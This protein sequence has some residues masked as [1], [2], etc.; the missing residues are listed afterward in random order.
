MIIGIDA[1]GTATKGALIS[2]EEEV[3][4]TFE[5]GYGNPLINEQKAF[6]HIENVMDA[7]KK[8]SKQPIQHI[9]IGM[10]GYRTMKDSLTLPK[11]W[12]NNPNI[13]V[14]SDVELAYEAG[15]PDQEGILTIAGTGTVH[16]GKKNKRLF[17]RGG[18]GHLLGDEGG[19]YT[20]G[21][22]AVKRVLYT[23]E[24]DL[25]QT[26]F[27]EKVMSFI[28]AYDVNE[29]KS[30]F[31]AQDKTSVAALAKFI[32]QLAI[33]G[34]QEAWQLLQE[35]ACELSRQVEQLYCRMELDEEAVL[36]VAGNVL[37]GSE[38][39]FSAFSKKITCPFREVRHLKR[40]AYMGAYSLAGKKKNCSSPSSH[41]I[42]E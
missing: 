35:G 21:R 11:S 34:D 7:C 18:W 15:L 42:F 12:Q 14:I 4:F 17:I 41:S 33:E 38:Q 24:M 13:D 8:A 22:S 40:P 19:G 23:L 1:G 6:E 9:V 31:Y 16:A 5:S 27:C 3:L 26:P 10:A 25:D 36:V 20:L 32:D 39:F 37:L 30:W 28:E 29:I 2:N